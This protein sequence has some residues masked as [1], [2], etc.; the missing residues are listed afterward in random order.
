VISD[1]WTE[2]RTE[3]LCELWRSGLSSS[4]VAARIGDGITRNAIIG[5]VHR[6]KVKRSK[7]HEVR[8][9]LHG[10]KR[11]R[12]KRPPGYVR[13]PSREQERK[14]NREIM[15]A[16][17][18][19]KTSAA[20]RKHLPRLGDMTRGELRAMLTTALQNTANMGDA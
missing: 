2:E 5:K 20:Y 4:Q 6:M 19:R 16:G 9:K 10:P 1:F 8:I 14:Q 12:I 3:L 7:G 15:L 18:A 11:V 13:P 17:G